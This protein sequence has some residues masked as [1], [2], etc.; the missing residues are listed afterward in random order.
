MT[1][2]TFPKDPAS[3]VPWIKK[4]GNPDPRNG[5]LNF[6][7]PKGNNV[8]KK[9]QLKVWLLDWRCLPSFPFPTLTH[10][11]TNPTGK[12]DK[13]KENGE[14]YVDVDGWCVHGTDIHTYIYMPAGSEKVKAKKSF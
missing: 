4:R 2:G 3:E 9:I 14:R 10:P 6:P 5:P 13:I 12:I 1:D 11:L 7:Y 8:N